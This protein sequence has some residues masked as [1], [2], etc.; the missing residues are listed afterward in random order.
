V[1]PVAALP[2]AVGRR[3]VVSLRGPGVAATV[4]GP[5]EAQPA[6]IASVAVAAIL[7]SAPKDGREWS[8][9]ESMAMGRYY[10]VRG[11]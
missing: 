4:I 8:L 5:F 7:V 3:I 9:D 6:T 2:V 10:G 11:R 1:L